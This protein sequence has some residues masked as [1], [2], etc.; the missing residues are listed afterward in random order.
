MLKE[1]CERVCFNSEVQTF[2]IY[3]DYIH[4]NIRENKN[5]TEAWKG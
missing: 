5:K 3:Y 2:E 1:L 4:F